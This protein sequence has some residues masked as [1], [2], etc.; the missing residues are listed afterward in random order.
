M[1]CRRETS[2]RAKPA[3]VELVPRESKKIGSQPKIEATQEGQVEVDGGWRV[4]C[5]QGFGKFVAQMAERE[6]ADC[7]FDVGGRTR[8]GE[9]EQEVRKEAELESCVF[10]CVGR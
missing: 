3:F 9:R 10:N 1:R 6:Y 2:D 7:N 4:L 5:G 8:K